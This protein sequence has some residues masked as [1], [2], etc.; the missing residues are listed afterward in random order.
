MCG[1]TGVSL[2]PLQNHG[3]KINAPVDMAIMSLDLTYLTQYTATEALSEHTNE[4]KS[5]T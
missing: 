1:I 2:L 4:L 3:T 5:L